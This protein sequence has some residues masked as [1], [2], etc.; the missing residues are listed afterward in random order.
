VNEIINSANEKINNTTPHKHTSKM[1]VITF[2]RKFASLASDEEL[3]KGMII[4]TSESIDEISCVYNVRYTR[5]NDKSSFSFLIRADSIGKLLLDIQQWKDNVLEYNKYV[6]QLK[7]KEESTENK[8]DDQISKFKNFLSQSAE[9]M[10]NFL[11]SS[12]E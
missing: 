5:Q 1:D 4:V 2:K 12:E 8:Y 11:S 6:S 10:F 3:N 7:R 9:Y